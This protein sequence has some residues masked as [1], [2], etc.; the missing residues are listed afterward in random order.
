MPEDTAHLLSPGRVWHLGGA[1]PVLALHCSLAHAGAWAG[2]AQTLSGITLTATDQPGHGRAPDWDGHSH[3][4]GLSSGQ[5]ISMAEEIGQG[6][7][8]DLFGH[9][10]GATIALRIALERPDLVRS[11]LLIE[12]VIFA[13][14]RAAQSPVWPEFLASHQGFEALVRAGKRQEAAAMFHGFWGNGEPFE[15]MPEKTRAYLSERIHFIVAQGPALFADNAGLL[16]YMGLESIGVPVLL[17]EGA[18]SPLVIDA[19]HTELARRLPNAQRLAIAGA[20]HM[21]TLTH[22]AELGPKVQAHLA[23]S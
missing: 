1:R 17:V 16:R 22:A 21:V 7:P 23:A 12:P 13:A 8:I 5:A 10:F 6:A 14:A 3:L 9:S 19:I 11:L 4:H 20:G 18:R 15:A 2:L